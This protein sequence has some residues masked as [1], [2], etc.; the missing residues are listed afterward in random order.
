MH[1]ET[2]EFYQSNAA[3]YFESTIHGDMSHAYQKFIPLIS[4]GGLVIDAGCG[5]GRDSRYFLS[6]GLVPLPFD[7]SSEMSRVV[8]ERTGLEVCVATFEN[9]VVPHEVEGIWACASLLHVDRVALPGII[10][11]LGRFLKKGGAFYL[12]FKSGD[13]GRVVNR[14]YFC[15]MDEA[16]S[17]K[18][19]S[20]LE[21]FHL[22]DYWPSIQVSSSV[23]TIWS[24]LLL[25]KN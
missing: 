13:E 25:Q 5:S 22:L 11:R 1:K 17:R 20:D 12:S 16:L 21:G 7:A 2:L 23:E 14:R 6:K 4:K 18:L 9:F 8:F 19:A 24:N 15:D 3:R 10:Q